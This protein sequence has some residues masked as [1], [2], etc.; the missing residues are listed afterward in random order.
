MRTH[1]PCREKP[2]AAPAGNLE[3]HED[4]PPTQGEPAAALAAAP[5]TDVCLPQLEGNVAPASAGDQ[6]PK[7]NS[8]ALQ[9]EP[10][11]TAPAPTILGP[12]L[13]LER[14]RGQFP[15]PPSSRSPPPLQVPSPSAP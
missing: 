15:K 2:A 10:A 4:S 5:D 12:A 9:G 13:A 3:P 14:A 6:G 1:Q 11:L 7:E 8:A